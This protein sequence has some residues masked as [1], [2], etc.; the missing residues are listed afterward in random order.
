MSMYNPLNGS[1]PDACAFKRLRRVKT[2]KDSEQFICIFHVKPDS[3]V[4]NEHHYL[5]SLLIRASYFDLSVRACA[6]EFYSI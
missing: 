2:L 1:Q 5:I 4:S 3:V 6:R